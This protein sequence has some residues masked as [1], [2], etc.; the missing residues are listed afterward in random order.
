MTYPEFNKQTAE[1]KKCILSI[2]R[3]FSASGMCRR[4]QPTSIVAKVYDFM[5]REKSIFF[6]YVSKNRQFSRETRR[7]P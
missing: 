7:N 1:A 6:I 5:E 4:A 2:V 3:P